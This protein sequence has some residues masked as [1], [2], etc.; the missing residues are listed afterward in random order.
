[1]SLFEFGV[2]LCSSEETTCIHIFKS[3]YGYQNNILWKLS[4][5]PSLNSR[6]LHFLSNAAYSMLIFKTH[7]YHFQRCFILYVNAC[8][9]NLIVSFHSKPQETYCSSE[10]NNIKYSKQLK[11]VSAVTV[12]WDIRSQLLGKS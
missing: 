7:H 1:M 12:W 6:F 2:H 5:S 9:I 4:S 10:A 8:L 3:G 11:F